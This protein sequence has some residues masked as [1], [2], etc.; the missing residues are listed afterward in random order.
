[1][2]DVV[3]LE[4]DGEGPDIGLVASALTR[5]VARGSWA[6]E[7]PID[8]CALLG[9]TARDPASRLAV[10]AGDGGELAIVLHGRVT[11]RAF[12]PRE[13]LALPRA[14]RAVPFARAMRG[15]CIPED[16]GARPVLVVA[17]EL[18]LAEARTS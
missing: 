4:V 16:M 5:V 10:V 14:L 7:A 9:M 6:G 2:I 11:L 12:G 3:V 17:P 15:I 1:V 13:L 8:V 18:L